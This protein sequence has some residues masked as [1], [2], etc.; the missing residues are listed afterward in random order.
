M[1]EYILELTI[2][3]ARG[4]KR[5]EELI[6]IPTPSQLDEWELYNKM[7][8]GDI[9]KRNGYAAFDDW[10]A[11]QAKEKRDREEWLRDRSFRESL[12]GFGK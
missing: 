3:R 9:R 10:E 5:V 2:E 1:D 11:F 6:D 8:G 4:Q 7:I 12:S